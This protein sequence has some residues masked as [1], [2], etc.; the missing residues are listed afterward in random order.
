MPLGRQR[1][2]AS[3]AQAVDVGLDAVPLNPTFLQLEGDA[4]FAV[5][6]SSSGNAKGLGDL[7]DGLLNDGA[8]G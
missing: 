5:P 1:T 8:G 4:D 3:V 2:A 7:F 6:F